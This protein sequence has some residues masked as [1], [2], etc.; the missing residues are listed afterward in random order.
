MECLK[1]DSQLLQPEV[2]LFMCAVLITRLPGLFVTNYDVRAIGLEGELLN[3]AVA[4][5]QL[6]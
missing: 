4:E 2:L 6:G 3:G 5:L 1:E